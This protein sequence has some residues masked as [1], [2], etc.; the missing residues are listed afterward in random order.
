MNENN[1]KSLS[2]LC[3]DAVDND[4]SCGRFYH[5]DLTHEY[6]FRST[7]HFLKV[8][9]S[10][11]NQSDPD[12]PALPREKEAIWLPGK[13]ATFRIQ[14]LYRQNA[15]WQGSIMWLETR[16]EEQFRSEIELLSIIHQALVPAQKQ[17]MCPSSLKITK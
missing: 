7:D 6:V 13:I 1:R 4:I 14:V 16:H 11:L 9:E 3:I 2:I 12:I 15:S 5:D 8:Y 17:R 10:I